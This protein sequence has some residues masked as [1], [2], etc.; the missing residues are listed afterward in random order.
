[1]LQ[2][3][4]L[5]IN[6]SA[7]TVV[8]LF[9]SCDCLSTTA[10]IYFLLLNQ[11]GQ[12]SR[13]ASTA[14]HTQAASALGLTSSFNNKLRMDMKELQALCNERCSL[15][16]IKYS[17][18]PLARPCTNYKCVVCTPTV[19]LPFIIACLNAGQLSF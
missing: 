9:V 2:N 11:E 4:Q 5:V 16:N 14:S 15:R 6:I 3:L 12:V 7:V 19:F 8:H 10:C 1:M 17:W 18:S 13:P